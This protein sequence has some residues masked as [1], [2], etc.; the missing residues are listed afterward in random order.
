MGIKRKINMFGT[1]CFSL[2]LL[3]NHTTIGIVEHNSIKEEMEKA[4]HNKIDEIP[5]IIQLLK[6]RF[7]GR[8]PCGCNDQNN[9]SLP[10]ICSAIQV[11]LYLWVFCYFSW[12]FLLSFK[13]IEG[14]FIE[15]IIIFMVSLCIYPMNLLYMLGVILKCDWTDSPYPPGLLPLI[16]E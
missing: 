6:S 14:T 4:V 8:S 5:N 12:D 15:D 11:A 9:L 7:D 10:I 2:L 1:L 16:R 3:S 13:I